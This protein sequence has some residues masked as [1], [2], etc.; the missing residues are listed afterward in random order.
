MPQNVLLFS[1]SYYFLFKFKTLIE[2]W[3]YK[4]QTLAHS[5]PSLKFILRDND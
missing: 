3:G 4:C 1:G 2:F 5:N